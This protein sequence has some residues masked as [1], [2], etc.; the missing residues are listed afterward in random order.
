LSPLQLAAPFLGAILLEVIH[1]YQLREVLHLK[2]YQR[3][4]RSVSYWVLT[5]LMVILGGVGALIV[6]ADATPVGLL[7]AGAAFPTVFK[8]LVAAFAEKSVTLGEEDETQ[9]PRAIEYF[10][11]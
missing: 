11:V 5:V 9:S 3:A 10:A 1:W 7:L 6:Y 8:K 4:L 2:K